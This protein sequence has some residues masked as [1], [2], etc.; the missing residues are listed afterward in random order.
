MHC[1]E[2]IHVII[3][4][5]QVWVI[6]VFSMRSM[7]MNEQYILNNVSLNRNMH[8]ILCGSVDENVIRNLQE[9][10]PIFPLGGSG[11]VFAN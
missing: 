3:N 11:S 1:E 5:I 10:N 8:K 9:S 4:F 2:N 7:L 6:V